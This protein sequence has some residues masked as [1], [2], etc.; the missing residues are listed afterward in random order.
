MY[1]YRIRGGTAIEGEIAVSG[2]KNAALPIM[3]ASILS[4]SESVL[5]NC[6]AISDVEKMKEILSGL[7]CRVKEAGETIIIDSSSLTSCKINGSLMKSMR[8]SIFLAGPLLSRCGHVEIHEPGGCNI[9]KRPIDIHLDAFKK[10]G[11]LCA[12]S[13]GRIILKA[14]KL[15]GAE[16]EMPFPS[17][18]AT[19]NI[20]AAAACAEGT[21]IIR[22][23]AKEPEIVDMQ[24]FL[25]GCGADVRG[26]G[27]DIIVIEG[28][29]SLH[30]TTHRI[31]PDRIEAG[32]FLTLAAITGGQLCLRGA[33]AS[34]LSAYIDILKRAGCTICEDAGKLGIK[35]PEK[36]KN[37]GFVET[38]GYPGFPTDLQS[39]AMVLAVFSEG[40]TRIRENVFERRFAVAKELNKMGAEIEIKSSDAIIKGGRKLRGAILEATDLRGG[41]ALTL[42]GV[43][44]SGESIVS[45]IEYIDR[46]YSRFEEKLTQV[47]ADIQRIKTDD[48][49]GKD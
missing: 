20:I 8:S 23:A 33:V 14:E 47:G 15:R 29:H 34:H 6:P 41:G 16:I 31:I 18:G 44:A 28:R 48:G 25:N 4:G 32:T 2:A 36:L 27:T 24:D 1:K 19:E 45:G 13:E 26:A 37:I 10:M 17:V 40:T 42:A 5:H 21:T 46:G 22:G 30:G 39:F 43:G 9:G 3:A 7:G 11:A 38:S 49:K 12:F 35:G